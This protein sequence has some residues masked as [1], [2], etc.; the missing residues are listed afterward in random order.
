MKVTLFKHLYCIG[1][2]NLFCK[3][4]IAEQSWILGLA[5]SVDFGGPTEWRQ[6]ISQS[7]G[8]Q[9]FIYGNPGFYLKMNC[10]FSC[11]NGILTLVVWLADSVKRVN[12]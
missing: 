10:C 7:N 8:K 9:A 3:Y 11:S 5:C 12:F 6:R 1:Y 4:Q 2:I